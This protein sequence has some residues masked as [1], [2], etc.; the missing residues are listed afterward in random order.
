MS[1]SPSASSEGAQEEYVKVITGLGDQTFTDH[2]CEVVSDAGEGAQ[3]CGQGFGSLSAKMGN[4]AW[5][6][7]IIPAEI[8]PPPRT[9]GSTSGVGIRIGQ[10]KITNAGD[11]VKLVIAFNEQVLLSRHR[12]NSMA[13]DCIVLIDS[14]WKVHKNPKVVA[15]W[16]AAML[17]MSTK[18][19]QW[20]MVPLEAETLKVVE[21]PKRGKN[22]F[23]LGILCHIYD[24]DVQ[25]AKDQIAMAFR[26]KPQA[27]TDANHKLLEAGIA[28][29]AENLDFRFLVPAT[30]P[31]KE[32]L[33]M[34][35]NEAFGMGAL[36]AGIDVCAMYP[37]TPASSVSHYLAEVYD[38]FG[39]M[40]HQAEDEIGA[41]GVALGVSYAGKTAMTITS[42]PGLALKAEFIGLALMAEIPLVV[43]DVQRGG[44]S[45]GLPTKVEQ[46][47]LLCVLYG[48][49]GDGPKIVIAPSTIEECFH[50]MTTA[51]QIAETL[52]TTVF[53]L[54]DANLATGV[55]PFERPKL[56]ASW[57][58]GP[59]D[60]TPVDPEARPYEWDHDTGL[61][62]RF[63]PG[64]RGGEHTVTGLNHDENSTVNYEPQTNELAH[65]MRSRKIAVFG[66]T[67][68][69]PIPHGGDEGDILIIG[70]GSTRG[71]IEE[72]VDR[73]RAKGLKASSL[74]LTF[75]SPLQPGIRAVCERFKKI[76]AVEINYSDDPDAPHITKDNRRR[77]QLAMLL[78]GQL[79][80]DCGSWGKV[81]G[82][83][84]QPQMLLGVIEKSIPKS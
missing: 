16:E 25:I 40:V 67:L 45:T 12:V 15:E 1:T 39:G 42:G 60:Q 34:N 4:G 6:V 30:P 23:G 3:K 43:I 48:Q 69:A 68:N 70:W 26:K 21:N 58:A 76:L 14:K 33:V 8:E 62:Q 11:A 37:I 22:M 53:I 54:S 51:R 28:W 55:T 19:Y 5:T 84:L 63:I 2:S 64:Q 24:R 78:R 74:H 27:V 29:A 61:S 31:T 49:P 71:S 47:D 38:K 13:D 79:L 18:N 46:S 81:P 66:E 20:I 36:A 82:A 10:G 59:P 80:I 41:I 72:A 73:A 57:M 44:P 83:P 50:I 56:E 17:E 65:A 35:G 9:P 52:R 77:G 75:L 32:L 7:E